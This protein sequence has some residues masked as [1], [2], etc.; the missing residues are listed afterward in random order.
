MLTGASG[1]VGSAVAE[2][3]ARDFRVVA[4][5]GRR[6]VAGY[7]Q[8]TADLTALRLGLRRET[9][10]GLAERADLV[11]HAAGNVDY[12]TDPSGLRAVNI[13]GTAEM[14]AFAEA[15]GCPLLYVSTA[16]TGRRAEVAAH[17]E[18]TGGSSPARPSRYLASKVEADALVRRCARP[19][20]IVRPSAVMGDSSGGFAPARQNAHA[21]LAAVAGGNLPAVFFRPEQRVDMVPRDLLAEAVA[22][23]ARDAVEGRPL[24]EEFWATAGPSALT[25]AEI[26]RAI[27][28]TVR[29]RGGTFQTP[30][31]L[32]PFTTS[33]DD[34][35]GWD[36][37]P[38]PFRR[39]VG[40]MYAGALPLGRGECFPTSMEIGPDDARAFLANDLAFVL[41]R[42]RKPVSLAGERR[43]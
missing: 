17:E 22:R 24:P 15:A 1:V 2:A 19:A 10:A 25:C 23:L 26:V 36:A 30:A 38:R 14:I 21:V 11:V 39:A 31:F 4:L 20:V 28:A 42:P 13:G 6:P 37:L 7:E 12:A 40:N 43:S 29:A 5:T 33:P 16:F 32:D 9:Y 35:P 34:F 41:A 27:G 8:V 3:L 18:R